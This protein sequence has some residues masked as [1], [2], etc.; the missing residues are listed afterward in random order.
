MEYVG[1]SQ[2]T[3]F[4][5]DEGVL[6][7]RN[8]RRRLNADGARAVRAIH[9]SGTFSGALEKLET[10]VGGTAR[11]SGVLASSLRTFLDDLVLDGFLLQ[12]DE[13]VC[14]NGRVIT[15]VRLR[16]FFVELL[17]GCNLTCSYCYADRLGEQFRIR[18]PGRLLEHVASSLRYGV[19]KLDLTGGEVFAYP[20]LRSVL[21]ALTDLNVQINLYSN[22]TLMRPDDIAF[23]D[24][25]SLASVITSIESLTPA[26]HD[27]IRGKVGA[28]KR[29]MDN[30]VALIDAGVSVR[31]N[32]VASAK[33]R[34]E[35]H[36]L[37]DYLYNDVGVTSIVIGSMFDVG[38]QSRKPVECVPDDELSR[39][40]AEVSSALYRHDLDAWKRHAEAAR[41]TLGHNGCGVGIDMLFLTSLGEYSLCPVLTPREGPEFKLGSLY[42]DEFDDVAQRFFDLDLSPRCSS[43]DDCDYGAMCKGGCR[44]RALFDKGALS[45]P[46]TNRCNYFTHL[47]AIKT[48]A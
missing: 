45:A 18:D 22:L 28:W 38:K 26:L 32:I 36:D 19:T 31:A 9:E 39:L 47:D 6:Q 40:N 37:C 1:L 7:N 34:H 13:E 4:H 44:A 30:V 46:D 35:I 42:E 29:T 10:A 15:D 21:S 3:L 5:G 27:E 20:H 8:R 16:R 25:V 48:D 24:S 41:D 23:L 17:S 12:G 14:T 11:A 43:V 33:N 2:H